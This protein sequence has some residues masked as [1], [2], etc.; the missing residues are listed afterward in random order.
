[1]KNINNKTTSVSSVLTTVSLDEIV[2]A[3][4]LNAEDRPLEEVLDEKKEDDEQS[5]RS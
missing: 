4:E 2:I 3:S 1:M 5:L